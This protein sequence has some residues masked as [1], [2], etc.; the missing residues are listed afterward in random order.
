MSNG[1]MTRSY[2]ECLTTKEKNSYRDRYTQVGKI[3]TKKDG[4]KDIERG[5]NR[6][7]IIK[8]EGTKEREFFLTTD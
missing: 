2:I 4:K 6:I 5:Q 1:G 8:K 7:G 3:E